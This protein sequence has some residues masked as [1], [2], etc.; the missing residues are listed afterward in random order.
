MVQKCLQCYCKQD[1]QFVYDEFLKGC[2]QIATH[3]HGCCV[4]QK[5]IG[6]A[7]PENK[8]KLIDKVIECTKFFVIDPFANYVV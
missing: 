5:C 6:N 4:L 8:A 1:S 2:I 7:D 3:K